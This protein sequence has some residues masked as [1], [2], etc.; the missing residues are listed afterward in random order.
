MLQLAQR[1]FHGPTGEGPAFRR[2]PKTI[3]TDGRT[4]EAP[5]SVKENSVTDP[6]SPPL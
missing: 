1:F 5:S 2:I 4:Q 3:T 6:E